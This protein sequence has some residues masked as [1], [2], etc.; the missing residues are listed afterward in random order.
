[1]STIRARILA[2]RLV[3][4]GW[5]RF[6]VATI[7]EETSDG[8]LL[9]HEREIIDHGDAAVVLVCDPE[10]GMALL[11]RQLRP[12]LLARGLDPFLLEACA[13]IIDPGETAEQCAVREAQE[14]LGV[15]PQRLRLVQTIVPSAGT[16]TERMH[17][18]LAEWS[19]G[20]P[21]GAGGGNRHEGET[22]EVVEMP[23]ADL[24]AAARQGRIEDAKTLVLVQALMLERQ[25]GGAGA[26]S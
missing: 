2:R 12:P 18:F 25:S 14:E 1:M 15:T 7:E 21:S 16:L 9:R 4:D 17:L 11:V 13:G 26:V 10:R 6:E 20:D 3:Y 19:A 23:L 22:I 5:N 8:H 24:F